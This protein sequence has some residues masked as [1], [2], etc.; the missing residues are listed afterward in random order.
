MA[1][2]A[3]FSRGSA[4]SLYDAPESAGTASPSA[5]PSSAAP[6]PMAAVWGRPAEPSGFATAPESPSAMQVDDECNRV[7]ALLQQKLK[8]LEGVDDSQEPSLR[9][10]LGARRASFNNLAGSPSKGEMR[11]ALDGGHVCVD[12][13]SLHC[14]AGNAHRCRLRHSLH[15]LVDL[16]SSCFT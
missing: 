2:H 6:L 9:F 7:A 13:C 8:M 15:D 5:Q 4:R 12:V 1:R 10:M 3:L 16:S 14:I 11:C